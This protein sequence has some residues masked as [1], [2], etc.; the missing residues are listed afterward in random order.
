MVAGASSIAQ[1][2]ER[3]FSPR[4]NGLHKRLFDNEAW[5]ASLDKFIDTRP[6]FLDSISPQKAFLLCTLMIVGNVYAENK[7]L[8]SSQN[9]IEAPPPQNDK[10]EDDEDVCYNPQ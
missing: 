5:R 9:V 4:L 2:T 3:M 7:G 1:T 8:E 10:I 6:E